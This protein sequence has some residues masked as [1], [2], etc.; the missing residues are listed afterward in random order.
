VS[1]FLEL[2]L[3]HSNRQSLS[4]ERMTRPTDVSRRLVKGS[5][6]ESRSSHVKD[7]RSTPVTARL[8]FVACA[9]GS[10]SSVV[11]VLSVSELQIGFGTAEASI[12]T[13][14]SGPV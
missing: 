14:N 10:T 8:S 2:S 7:A 12:S 6:L 1:D 13:S 5:T 9:L 4:S 3:K 11:H